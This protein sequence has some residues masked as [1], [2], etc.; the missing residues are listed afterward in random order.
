MTGTRTT[1]ATRACS[2]PPGFDGG[3]LGRA[4]CSGS[5]QDLWYAE[6]EYYNYETFAG[7][8]PKKAIGHFTS[9]SG[10]QE[11]SIGA[12]GIAGFH[13][14]FPSFAG[15]GWRVVMSAGNRGSIS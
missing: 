8:D 2:G 11:L 15:H 3:P 12:V 9:S 14:V 13:V 4:R 10:V 5:A 6:I 7:N 1:A